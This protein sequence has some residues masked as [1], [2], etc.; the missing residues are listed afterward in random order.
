MI[1]KTMQFYFILLSY[2][3]SKMTIKQ[4]FAKWMSLN[5]FTS[6]LKKVQIRR[7]G[8]AEKCWIK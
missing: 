7:D 6:G 3:V 5:S 8:M 1:F 2:G 4:I